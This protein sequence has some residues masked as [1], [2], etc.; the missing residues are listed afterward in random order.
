MSDGTHGLKRWTRWGELGHPRWLWGYL[1]QQ[2]VL[3]PDYSPSFKTTPPACFGGCPAFFT[4]GLSCQEEISD[5][6][7]AFGQ[8][9]RERLWG[10]ESPLKPGLDGDCLTQIFPF[11]KYAQSSKARVSCR[12]G[13]DRTARKTET[14]TQLQLHSEKPQTCAWLAS[15]GQPVQARSW[16]GLWGHLW[17]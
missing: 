10:M 9:Q 13:C 2:P 7:E 4:F 1:C 16:G 8:V 12:H 6:E 14:R 11:Q 5:Q 15:R 17:G 3:F